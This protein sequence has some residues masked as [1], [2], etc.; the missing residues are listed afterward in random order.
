MATQD[1]A[2]L[3]YT[4]TSCNGGKGVKCP[5][6]NKW[7]CFETEESVCSQNGFKY[8]CSGTGYSG[9]SGDS[10]GGKYKKCNC[11]SG[12]E[13]SGSACKKESCSSSYKYTCSATGYAGG[14]GSACGG[15]YAQCTCVSGYEWKD[16]AC[17]QQSVSCT[18]GALYYSDGKCYDEYIA[19]KTLLGVVIYEKSSGS[20]GW[21]MTINPIQ[22]DIVWATKTKVI[23]GLNECASIS[24]LTDIQASCT[25]TDIITAYGNS[26][27]YPAAWVA[28][29]YK[30]AGTPSGKDWCLPSGGLLKTALDNSSNFTKVN[31][32]IIAAKGTILGEV[33]HTYEFILSSSV[34]DYGGEG[35]D[36]VWSFYAGMN[37]LFNMTDSGMRSSSKYRE[38]FSVRPVMAF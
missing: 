32:G 36:S 16:G 27:I 14:A 1:C 23:P 5:F 2:T 13:W 24:C 17:Q 26:S 34:Y 12:Y 21:I 7:C 19:S 10:C 4:E 37:G 9:G 6:G 28:K 33:S 22:T 31:D 25:N 35:D 29:N 38:S 3:G 11:Q 20:N 15:K 30:P 18:I 8:A